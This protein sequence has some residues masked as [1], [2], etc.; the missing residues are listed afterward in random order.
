MMV[1]ASRNLAETP[2]RQPVQAEHWVKWTFIGAT[3]VAFRWVL[4]KAKMLTR[5]L[6]YATMAGLAASGIAWM[7]GFFR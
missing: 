7:L 6:R 5:F 2:I 4:H 1:Q 3:T